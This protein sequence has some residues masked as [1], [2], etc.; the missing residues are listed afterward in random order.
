M[1]FEQK[2]ARLDDVYSVSEYKLFRNGRLLATLPTNIA[3]IARLDDMLYVVLEVR[4]PQRDFVFAGTNLWALDL[5]GKTVWK[6]PNVNSNIE[7]ASWVLCY[8]NLRIYDRDNPKIKCYLDDRRW[9]CIDAR[10]G[11]FPEQLS[12][13]DK[14]RWQTDYEGAMRQRD[15]YL[16]KQEASMFL[17]SLR[18]TVVY[19]NNPKYPTTLPHSVVR[20]HAPA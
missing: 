17:E 12:S 15:D 16:E 1:V 18:L 5:D 13:I 11:Q 4:E 7:L 19:P 6:A 14:K 20:S 10:T 8:S 3:E 9:A 2:L